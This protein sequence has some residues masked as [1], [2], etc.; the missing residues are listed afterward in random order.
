MRFGRNYNALSDRSGI[1]QTE[2]EREVLYRIKEVLSKPHILRPIVKAIN[3]RK[4]NRVKPLQDELQAI[5]IRLREIQ[6]TKLKYLEL[7]ELDQVERKLFSDRLAELENELDVFHARRSELEIE[8]DG[9]LPQEVSYE[10]VRSLIERF[11]QL[12]DSSSFDQ[13]KTLLHLIIGKITVTCDKR[14]EN[15]EMIFDELTE[16]HFL[17]SAP[18]AAQTVE[19]AFHVRGSLTSKLTVII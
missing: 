7:Y 6:K 8:L 19:G 17:R 5:H 1:R 4:V 18:S 3:D 2:A 12:L 11:D 14:I 15:I 9:D 13:R 10:T 16:Q